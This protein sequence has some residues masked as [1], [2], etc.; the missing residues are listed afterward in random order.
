MQSQ[1]QSQRDEKIQKMD[2]KAI[3]DLANELEG[4]PKSDNDNKK[5]L[6]AKKRAQVEQRLAAERK[7]YNKQN[8]K[9]GKGGADD[10]DG[11]DYLETFAKGGKGGK[12]K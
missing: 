1:I 8:N 10:D 12:K 2:D 3:D 5:K 6:T 11:D 4:E 9:K 7:Q